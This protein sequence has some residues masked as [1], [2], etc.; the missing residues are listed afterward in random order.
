MLINFSISGSYDRFLEKLRPRSRP[1]LL[2][3]FKPFI[4]LSEWLGVIIISFVG[5]GLFIFVLYGTVNAEEK[6]VIQTTYTKADVFLNQIPI[7]DTLYTA[8]KEIIKI[9]EDPS[10]PFRRAGWQTEIDDSEDNLNLG[11]KFIEKFSPNQ[12]TYLLNENIKLTTTA[13]LQALENT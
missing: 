11:L 6:G 10:R 13:Q 2:D 7:V 8:G 12:G 9:E 3:M 4:I 5:L 1:R